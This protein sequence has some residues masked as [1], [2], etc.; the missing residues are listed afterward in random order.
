MSRAP[1]VGGEFVFHRPELSGTIRNEKNH[2]KKTIRNYPEIAFVSTR[3]R[4][5]V[6]PTKMRQSILFLL[7]N[8]SRRSRRKRKRR[9]RRRRTTGIQMGNAASPWHFVIRKLSGNYPDTHKSCHFET[10]TKIN[11]FTFQTLISKKGPTKI[12]IFT[13]RTSIFVECLS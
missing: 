7:T 13:F 2:S 5:A 9:R 1:I 8:R 11:M 3:I 4:R 6:E 12:N 10:S